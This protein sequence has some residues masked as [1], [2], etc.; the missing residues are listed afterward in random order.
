MQWIHPSLMTGR[1]RILGLARHNPVRIE[2]YE[3][4]FPVLSRLLS[5]ASRR[6]SGGLRSDRRRESVGDSARPAFLGPRPI[7]S[8]GPSRLPDEREFAHA[9][10][11]LRVVSGLARHAQ[12]QRGTL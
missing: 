11:R 1:F 4:V 2:I 8:P 10:E 12:Q 9:G 5:P 3:M 6:G 7:R